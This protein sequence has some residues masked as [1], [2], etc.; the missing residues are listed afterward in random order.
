MR[1]RMTHRVAA[2][3]AAAG[4]RRRSHGCGAGPDGSIVR[5]P[6]AVMEQG[7]RGRG[8]ACGPR[9]E[10]SG[11]PTMT[12]DVSRMKPLPRRYEAR[13]AAARAAFA[14]WALLGS[15]AA[16]WAQWSDITSGPL[17]APGAGYGASWADYDGDGDLDLCLTQNFSSPQ[18]RLF[19]NDGAGV[20]VDATAGPLASTNATYAALWADA[21]NDGDL[22][23]FRVHNFE[24]RNVL[25]RND[26]GAFTEAPYLFS[27]KGS[28]GGA[29]WG[30]YDRDGRV[31]IAFVSHFGSALLYRN[32]GGLTFAEGPNLG[33]AKLVIWVDFDGDGD[34]DLH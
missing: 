31:D 9:S 8:M 23:L 28:A 24:P 22:D 10:V 15:T 29:A 17:A 7:S 30:D 33:A 25:Y 19:R 16:A 34:L 14:V 26:A 21:D 18:L 6:G 2:R 11:R 13:R 4:E 5:A 27:T 20:F 32:L 1:R 12:R 3:Q